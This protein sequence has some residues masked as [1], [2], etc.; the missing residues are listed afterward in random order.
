MLEL[1]VIGPFLLAAVV[2]E[3]TPGPNM[4]WLAVVSMQR[5]R[6]AGLS[7]VLGVTL[8]LAAWML[9]AA[10][11]LA[12]LL[13]AAPGL[14]RALAWAGVAFMLYLAW[15]SW[16][17]PSTSAEP[18][19]GGSGLR[20]FQRGLIGNLLNPKAAALY[21]T[22]LPA[23]ARTGEA[24]LTPGAILTL[25]LLHLGISVAVHG[26]IVLTA[27][28]AGDRMVRILA[29]TWSRGL[30]AAALAMIALWLGWQT[31]S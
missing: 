29:A 26:A 5:G 8:G 6:R 20:L 31:L 2:M 21:A 30:M 11:G 4:G 10:A 27:S 1:D 17:E 7:A 25:G 19:G 13:S 28:A 3:L 15:E 24:D 16:R 9:A 22:V 18:G 23:F 14:Y 12:Q